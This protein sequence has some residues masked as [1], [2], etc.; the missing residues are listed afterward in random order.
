MPVRPYIFPVRLYILSVHPYISA[1]RKFIPAV[2]VFNKAVRAFFLPVRMQNKIICLRTGNFNKR[3]A[4]L[5]L[6]FLKRAINGLNM[7][8][9]DAIGRKVFEKE[10]IDSKN[11]LIIVVKDFAK[12][13]YICTIYNNGKPIQNTK[14]IKK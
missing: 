3:I 2:P 7:Q 13:N 12:G 9:T 8:I 5:R 10:L 6:C 1:V 14:F 4:I 11:Q